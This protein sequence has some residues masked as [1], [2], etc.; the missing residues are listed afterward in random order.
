MKYIEGGVTAPQG[1]LASGVCAGIK[2]GNT[3]KND[4]AIIYSQVP[5][6]DAGVF[7]TNAVRAA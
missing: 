3:S 6:T 2:A 7:T 1:F 4:V 5:C